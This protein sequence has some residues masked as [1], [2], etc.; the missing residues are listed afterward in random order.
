MN[1]LQSHATSADDLAAVAALRNLPD[2]SGGK[3]FEVSLG[4]ARALGLVGAGSGID[5][6]VTLNSY[7]W[8]ST[9]LQNYPNDVIAVLEHEISEGALGRFG[10]LGTDGGFW[11]IMD[12]F[13]FTAAGQRDFT[14]GKD[15]VATYFSIDG[16]SVDT[17]LRY[18]ASINSA[19]VDD[20][21]DLADWDQVGANA[22]AHDPFGPGGP[23]AGR[24]RRFIA[25]RSPNYG[26]HW[27]D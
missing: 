9:A 13:R 19:G 3:G 17:G 4:E 12:L 21:F 20:G 24:S 15:G 27:L 16:S 6:A 23:G 5:D 7:Y 26:C 2:P 10:S 14:G 22:N 11:A 8:T 25:N 1:A 18:H